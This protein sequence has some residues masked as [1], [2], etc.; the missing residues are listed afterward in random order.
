MSPSLSIYNCLNGIS[1]NLVFCN[2]FLQGMILRVIGSYRTNRS[3]CQDGNSTTF[4]ESRPFPFV[5]ISNV[6]RVCARFQMVRVNTLR[7]ITFVANHQ[8]VTYGAVGQFKCYAMRFYLS[9]QASHYSVAFVRERA[10]PRPAFICALGLETRA[11]TPTPGTLF[12]FICTASRAMLSASAFNLIGAAV[13]RL[14]AVPTKTYDGSS[15]GMNLIDRFVFWS[16]PFR[17]VNFCAGRFV[18]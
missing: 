2:K 1:G 12:V 4:P 9:P 14:P 8:P 10:R 3:L 5:T 16:G 17:S 11:E 15:H 7:I 6:I 13:K 18:F